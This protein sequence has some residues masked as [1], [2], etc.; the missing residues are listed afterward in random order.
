[1]D[2]TQIFID[3]VKA[4]CK[5]HKVKI[6]EYKRHYVKLTD[7]VKCGGYFDDSSKP[8]ILAFAKGRPDYLELLVHEYCHMTQWLDKLP[9]WDEAESALTLMWSWLGGED[10]K[11]ADVEKSIDIA[12]RLE[13]DN[14][15]RSVEMIK[16]FNL[17]IDTALYT[18]KANAYVL[19]YNHLKDTRRWSKPENTPYSNERVLAAMSDKFDMDYDHLSQRLANLFINEDI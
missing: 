12:K 17:P 1:M 3:H 11:D 16:R 2:S 19:F 6:K 13:L 10:W 7:G 14:E 4:E 9:L 18:K 15:K 8:P 5:K